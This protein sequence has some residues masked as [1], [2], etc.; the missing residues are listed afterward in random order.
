MHC[1][2]FLRDSLV[3]HLWQMF[4]MLQFLSLFSPWCHCSSFLRRAGWS[5][6][7]C[8]FPLSIFDFPF[9]SGFPKLCIIQK[10]S[11]LASLHL[12]NSKGR[13]SIFFLVNNNIT[14]KYPINCP[15]N[16]K[17]FYTCTVINVYKFLGFPLLWR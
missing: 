17:Y 4:P 14:V 12:W 10:F 9:L 5:F 15:T 7:L 8:R 1:I 13:N 11:I 2:S 6:L 3:S 16:C